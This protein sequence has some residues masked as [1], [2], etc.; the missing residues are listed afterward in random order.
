MPGRSNYEGVG[1]VSGPVYYFIASEHC[2]PEDVMVADRSRDP[3]RECRRFAHPSGGK[4][5]LFTRPDFLAKAFPPPRE[6]GVFS[7]VLQRRPYAPSFQ[8]P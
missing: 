4:E 5:S 8:K 7:P 2:T 3:E 1:V 6:G